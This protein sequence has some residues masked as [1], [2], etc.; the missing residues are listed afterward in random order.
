MSQDT[1]SSVSPRPGPYWAEEPY[2]GPLGRT[3]LETVHFTL[4][5]GEIASVRVHSVVNATTDPAV[6]ERLLSGNLNWVQPAGSDELQQV[7]LPVIFHSEERRLF[8]LVL[9]EG[10]R[11]RELKERAALFTRLSQD[12]SV[13]VP[14]YVLCFEVVFSVAD[15][16]ALL[17]GSAPG[18]GIYGQE[19]DLARREEQ[20]VA[21]EAKLAEW[22]AR[23]TQE[24]KRLALDLK[25]REL[26][27]GQ[28]SAGLQA[29]LRR[30]EQDV[31]RRETELR[32]VERLMMERQ[33]DLDR[34]QSAL[35]IRPVAAADPDTPT[36]VAHRD[37][38]ERA[39]REAEEL[40]EE[41]ANDGELLAHPV[42][43]LGEAEAPFGGVSSGSEEAQPYEPRAIEDIEAETADGVDIANEGQRGRR[44][45]RNQQTLATPL[46]EALL[47]AVAE[48][49]ALPQGNEVA[50]ELAK[51]PT[52][53][54]RG[55][56]ADSEE[57]GEGASEALALPPELAEWYEEGD[58]GPRWFLRETGVHLAAC[59]PAAEA[60]AF[61]GMEPHGLLQLH[62]FDSFAWITLAVVASAGEEMQP[63]VHWPLDV[64]DDR[65]RELLER[66]AAD[67]RFTL[68]VYD[69]LLE[70]V[71]VQQLH[72]PLEE[73][74]RVVRE[75]AQQWIASL[76]TEALDPVTAWDTFLG[77]AYPRLEGGA[78]DFGPNAFQQIRSAAGV[79]EAVALVATW[80]VP[81]MEDELILRRSFP[82][83]AWRALRLRVLGQALEYGIW[84]DRDLRRLA[85]DAGYATSRRDLLRAC[86][87]GFERVGLGELE[88]GL[89]PAQEH[90]NWNSLLC[91]AED[92]GVP[93]ERQ[94][95][96]LAEQARARVSGAVRESEHDHGPGGGY[97]DQLERLDE[98]D[99]LGAEDMG[100]GGGSTEAQH[101]PE[102]PS[103]HAR[104]EEDEDG[105]SFH[106]AAEPPD[107]SEPVNVLVGGAEFPSVSDPSPG[108]L[109]ALSVP[110]LVAMLEDPR[111]RV[112]AALA[113]CQ[114][115]DRRATPEI[116]ALLPGLERGELERLAPGLVGLGAE[117]VPFFVES[118]RAAG[119]FQRATSALALGALGADAAL[120]SMI[121]LL[122][123]EPTEQWRSVATA[124]GDLGR[125]AMMSLASRIRHSGEEQKGRI[126]I[127]MAE[128]AFWDGTKELLVDLSG[129]QDEEAARVSG[130][131]LDRLAEV[132]L[133]WEDRE[134]LPA[135]DQP[136]ARFSR[137]LLDVLHRDEGDLAEDDIIEAEDIVEESDV[138]GEELA[139]RGPEA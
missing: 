134:P 38:M 127:A 81:D 67:F 123:D 71:S 45:A 117:A 26:L 65:A 4:P 104:D 138:L 83:S 30:R 74:V 139:D 89:D 34:Q 60:E 64:R 94:W 42:M 36:R 136:A 31:A 47:A 128:V 19:P 96:T 29:E 110:E 102:D 90:E 23:L 125:Q 17:V 93:M 44:G 87:V 124:L 78:L 133:L 107:A 15:L 70:P 16:E 108:S 62:R 84:M 21:R 132:Q 56:T 32:E 69:E 105:Q 114:G 88:S 82:A 91:E 39:A 75:R 103:T 11:G 119:S 1:R 54:A 46:S 53:G 12:S 9:P 122:L 41:L 57:P 131:A 95:E 28:V 37:S 129:S 98:A 50:S 40:A 48:G 7:L 79:A 118:L 35:L 18:E 109:Q 112:D 22:E 111:L 99:L 20:I 10:Y 59:L 43:P 66:L 130:Q 14:K 116:F 101:E 51:G 8:V 100:V 5:S 113:L 135:L 106:D 61:V 2:S 77:A 25:Q 6:S 92:L 24:E 73:N 33:A 80:S 13:P 55:A 120:E 49:A 52:V 97:T 68:E 86:L 85:L 76:P 137:R 121:D 126:A 27:D 63:A 115:E 3:R 58:R 72:Y